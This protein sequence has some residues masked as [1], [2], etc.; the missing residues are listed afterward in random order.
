MHQ[1][2]PEFPSPRHPAS[3]PPRHSESPSSPPTQKPPSPRY[4]ESPP[5]PSLHPKT[6]ITSPCYPES[7]P[8][9]SLHLETPIITPKPKISITTISSSSFFFCSSVAWLRETPT[10]FLCCLTE[11]MEMNQG[12]ELRLV[13]LGI[14]DEVLVSEVMRNDAFA[15]ELLVR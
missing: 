1:R 13:R 15:F 6:S 9:P 11:A 4:P 14:P 3:P 7:P 5:P 2:F 10:N 12:F 8:P